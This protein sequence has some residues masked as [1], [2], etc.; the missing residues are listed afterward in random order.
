[1]LL[2]RTLSEYF[3]NSNVYFERNTTFSAKS[4]GI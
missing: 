2:L 3:K 1:M 4:V